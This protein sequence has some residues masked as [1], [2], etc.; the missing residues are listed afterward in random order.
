M[1]PS[2]VGQVGERRR[3]LGHD[4]VVVDVAGDRDRRGLAG[5]VG[6]EELADV[7]GGDRAHRVALAGGV[8]AEAVVGEQ[9][10]G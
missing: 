10:A 6:G 8:A 3:H 7:V 2:P 9:L 5:V 1:R 4:V